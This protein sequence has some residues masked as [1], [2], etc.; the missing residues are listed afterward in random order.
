LHAERLGEPPAGVNE[1]I[2]EREKDLRKWLLVQTDHSAK[3]RVDT[4]MSAAVHFLRRVGQ[5]AIST[6]TLMQVLST[7]PIMNDGTQFT[8]VWCPAAKQA[9]NSI[10]RPGDLPGISLHGHYTKLLHER[11][12]L[13]DTAMALV[14]AAVLL[15]VAGGTV[16]AAKRQGGHFA[17][18]GYDAIPDGGATETETGTRTSTSA[19]ALR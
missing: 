5:D 14:C 15:V 11:Q 17:K 4:K 10:L 9:V 8:T 3:D 2:K 7:F 19:S 16:F 13:G 18:S 1:A 6:E 12:G